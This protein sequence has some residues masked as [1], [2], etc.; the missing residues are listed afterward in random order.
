M[1]DKERSKKL[2]ALIKTWEME[3]LS[4]FGEAFGVNYTKETSKPVKKSSLVG[5]RD[6]DITFMSNGIA[7]KTAYQARIY[8]VFEYLKTQHS[9][10]SYGYNCPIK[11]NGFD[12]FSMR[13]NVNSNIRD[14]VWKILSCLLCKASNVQNY[15][16]VRQMENKEF[17]GFLNS[18]DSISIKIHTFPIHP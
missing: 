2:S 13:M 18:G 11:I 17:Y 12:A 1:D 15:I 16:V 7:D 6:Y 5:E 10:T 3:M 4:T 8:E 9:I 14:I